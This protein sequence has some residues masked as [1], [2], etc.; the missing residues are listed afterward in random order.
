M[1]SANHQT[2]QRLENKM[3]NNWFDGQKVQGQYCGIQY[4]GTIVGQGEYGTRN[5]PDYKNWIYAI[6]LDSPIEVF[7][8]TREKLEIWSNGTNSCDAQ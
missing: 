1:Y 4:T 6:V 7:G 2:Y 3:L 8:Q 5:T